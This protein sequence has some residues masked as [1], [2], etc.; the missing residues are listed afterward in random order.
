MTAGL[1]YVRTFSSL[2]QIDYADLF[3][4]DVELAATPEQWARAMFG[5]VP[6]LAEQVIWR[7]A[8]RLRLSPER[9]PDTVGG[10]R[11]AGRG[12][13]WLRLEAASWLLS[14]NLVVVTGD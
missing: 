13:D 8:L 4:L 6:S 3:S 10:W 11:I 9:S 5:D 12:D 7:G 1:E 2:P 14:G